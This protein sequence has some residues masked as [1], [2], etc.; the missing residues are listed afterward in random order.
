MHQ[1]QNPHSVHNIYRPTSDLG[2]DGASSFATS[3]VRFER[4]PRS[5]AAT[6]AAAV[7]STKPDTRTGHGSPASIPRT[8]PAI[9]RLPL[10]IDAPPRRI[11]RTHPAVG[12]DDPAGAPAVRRTRRGGGSAAASVASTYT[13]YGTGRSEP[14]ATATATWGAAYSFAL[15]YGVSR[16][17]AG[18]RAHP[19]QGP[20]SVEGGT[21]RRRSD[22]ASHTEHTLV[23][24]NPRATVEVVYLGVGASPL[25]PH[26][27]RCM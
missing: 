24:Y 5:W 2:T 12:R 16:R 14:R 17:A 22:H 19:C 11:P 6:V 25:H 15:A 21:R 13:S 27:S 1:P 4:S 18:S 7:R 9:Y 26:R 20:G 23:S 3:V 10:N 8:L